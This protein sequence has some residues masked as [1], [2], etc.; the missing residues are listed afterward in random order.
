MVVSIGI[1]DIP[2]IDGVYGKATGLFPPLL[3]TL[4]DCQSI[5]DGTPPNRYVLGPH[6]SQR[7]ES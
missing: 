6:R 4:G 1:T 3:D 7:R 2:A 5:V